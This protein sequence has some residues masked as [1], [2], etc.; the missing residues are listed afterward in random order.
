MD[1]GEARRWEV[2]RANWEEVARW[3]FADSI[4][5]GYEKGTFEK[6]GV[7]LDAF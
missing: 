5:E 4:A 1:C 7:A 3:G 2:R 6:Y